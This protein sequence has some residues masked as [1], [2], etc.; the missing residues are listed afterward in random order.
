M[1]FEPAWLGAT[2]LGAVDEGYQAVALPRGAPDYFDWN[3]VLLNGI[4]AAFGALIVVMTGFAV[5]Q[6]GRVPSVARWGG[7]ALAIAIAFVTNPP[8]WSP[9]SKRHRADACFTG[10]PRPNRW[11]YWR[12]RMVWWSRSRHESDGGAV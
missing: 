11:W 5:M 10:C 2:L 4:G 8:V 6:N 12:S 7:V 3:D 1:D 9:F